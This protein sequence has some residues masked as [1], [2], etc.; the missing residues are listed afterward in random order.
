MLDPR[1]P[2]HHESARPSVSNTDGPAM[3]PDT[4]HTLRP[5]DPPSS[6]I[7]RDHLL[8]TG[9]HG[10]V[11]SPPALEP[12][13]TSTGEPT[14]RLFEGKVSLVGEDGQELT[15]DGEILLRVRPSPDVL[16][17]ARFD[18]AV[19]L[20]EGLTLIAT[21]GR[22]TVSVSRT[23]LSS[24]GCQVRARL[25][26]PLV[27]LLQDER[28]AVEVRAEILNFETELLGTPVETNGGGSQARRAGWS[29]EGLRFTLDPVPY[30]KHSRSLLADGDGYAV[31]HVLGIRRED[32]GSLCAADFTQLSELLYD[33]LSICA[34]SYL[35]IG[36]SAGM[37]ASGE[38]VW[39]R[40]A[41][42][43]TQHWRNRLTWLPFKASE[44]L[45]PAMPKLL[46][47]SGQHP[48]SSGVLRNLTGALAEGLREG[49][50]EIRLAT[51]VT[52]LELLAWAL[53][54]QD[55]GMV[56]EADF[57]NR[58]LHTHIA[59]VLSIDS[60]PLPVPANLTAL[61][62]FARSCGGTGP[63][64]VVTVRNRVVH[65]PTRGRQVPS[66]QVRIEAW[67][68]AIRYLQLGILARC[69]YS[70]ET[71]TPWSRTRWDTC[72][73]PWFNAT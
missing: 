57:D 23:D 32:G 58:R 36:C 19:E 3:P 69:G 44:G 45:E 18:D 68:L 72:P 61:R 71:L 65:P 13:Y 73:V 6:R 52:G 66:A 27:R 50:I 67:L 16:L 41:I 48:W 31:T 22:A 11:P 25:T 17:S 64:A 30:S 56:P 21:G 70:G 51:L 14:S 5:R 63:Q 53:L 4:R 28:E 24:A 20:G 34:G 7:F 38:R 40:W 8:A 9:Q 47:L 37:T 54:V 49:S 12:P 29:A 43:R 42:G 60:V 10:L 62:S 46:A 1:A 15:G 26:S 33:A 2:L 39:E 35:G 55:R 59:Q